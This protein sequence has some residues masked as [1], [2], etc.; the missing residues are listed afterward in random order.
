M[1]NLPT[2]DDLIGQHAAL[3]ALL[4]DATREARRLRAEEDG[5]ERSFALAIVALRKGLAAHNDA[6]EAL[7]TPLLATQDRAGVLR[8]QRMLEEHGA[9]HALFV[10][11][12]DRTLLVV[13]AKMDALAEDLEAHMQAEERTFLSPVVFA[14]KRDTS[15]DSAK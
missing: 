4:A 8:A 9:E 14:T 6:E 7:L 1:A 2:R 12:L 5:A 10:R 3:R 11:L 15:A 13:A